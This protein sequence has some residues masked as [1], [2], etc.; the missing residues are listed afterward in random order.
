MRTLS[1]AFVALLTMNGPLSAQSGA[2]LTT[3]R[4]VADPMPFAIPSMQIEGQVR[5]T[6]GNRLY[7]LAM[8]LGEEP[9]D[10]E[11]SGF[12][13]VGGNGTTYQPIGAGARPDLIVPLD[14]LPVGTQVGEILP[15]DA[16]LSLIRRS[17]TS[18]ALEVGPRGTVAFLYDLPKAMAVRA[19]RL[20]DGRELAIT[21]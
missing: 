14:S 10:S 4:D 19:L 3:S 8:V 1:F 21:P 5:A 2:A 11:V 17:T 9:I 20:P 13:V 12:L 7:V 16:I 18:T 6:A 15:S